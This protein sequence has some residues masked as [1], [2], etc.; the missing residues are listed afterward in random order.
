VGDT[1]PGEGHFA[2]QLGVSRAVMREAFGALA[3]LR[4]I[5]VANGRRARVGAMDG[6]IMAASLDHAVMTAQI[7]VADIWDVR[8]TVELRI[9]ALAAERRT[10]AQAAKIVELANAMAG[11]I[12]DME[13]TTRY[14]IAFHEAIAQAAGNPLFTQIVTSFA[15]LMK[16]AVSAA[17]RTRDT[18]AE[19]RGTIDRHLGLADAIA[20]GDVAAAE[21]AMAAHFETAVGNSLDQARRTAAA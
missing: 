6:S 4:V 15:P 18:D 12:G 2:N 1:L 19:R 8:R 21:A 17:W 13:A 20:R 16:V 14:D 3:A 10:E 11:S 9:A 7:E 5:D